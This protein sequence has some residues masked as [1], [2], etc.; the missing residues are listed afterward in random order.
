VYIAYIESGVCVCGLTMPESG[1]QWPRC[2]PSP[3]PHHTTPQFET[4]PKEC[5]RTI[6]TAMDQFRAGS[7]VPVAL[8]RTWSGARG[9]SLQRDSG[10]S[11]GDA[12]RIGARCAP[13]TQSGPSKNPVQPEDPAIHCHD[14]EFEPP[15]NF[16]NH[17]SNDFRPRMRHSR[18]VSLRENRGKMKR[19]AITSFSMRFP[20]V[21]S[22]ITCQYCGESSF[23]RRNFE[24]DNRYAPSIVEDSMPRGEYLLLQS[25]AYFTCS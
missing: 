19:C 7:P 5:S 4:R 15:T 24:S 10:G 14:S 23:H 22:P 12:R 17:D 3:A 20:M 11:L 25:I 16:Q 1:V 13:C 8:R 18:G 6:R 2:R 9:A 21:P